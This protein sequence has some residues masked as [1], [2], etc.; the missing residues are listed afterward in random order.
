MAIVGKVL[1]PFGFKLIND[2]EVGDAVVN[3]DGT[4]AHVIAVSP[5]QKLPCYKVTFKDGASIVV[6]EGHLWTVKQSGKRTRARATV[7]VTLT[8]EEPADRFNEELVM[9]YKV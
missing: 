7:G 8:C 3:P 2:V 5:I 9:R 6:D 1:T 4:T